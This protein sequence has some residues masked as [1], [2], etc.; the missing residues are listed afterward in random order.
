MQE[1]ISET[2]KVWDLKLSKE[3]IKVYIKTSGG[4]QF[5]KEQPYIKCEMLF[6]AAYS[7]RKIIEVIFNPKHRS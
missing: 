1:S 7:M 5:N 2:N 3:D 4:S 6:N